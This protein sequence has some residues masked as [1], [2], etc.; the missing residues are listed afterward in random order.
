MKIRPGPAGQILRNDYY[1]IYYFIVKN[2][3]KIIC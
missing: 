1:L 3:N 2:I